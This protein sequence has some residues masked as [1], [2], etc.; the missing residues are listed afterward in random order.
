MDI[1]RQ[2][3]FI[4]RW[5]TYFPGAELPIAFF[6]TDEETT[7]QPPPAGDGFH[8]LICELRAVREGTPRRF[9]GQTTRCGGARRYL[10]FE[11]GLRP[12]FPYFL[13]CGI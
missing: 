13:S 6:Y 5:G 1:A 12:T 2:H 9:D 4:D 10:G 7:A 3:R 8:C 11:T